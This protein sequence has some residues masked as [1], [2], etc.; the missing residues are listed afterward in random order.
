V[1]GRR[2][3]RADAHR[4]AAALEAQLSGM[5]EGGSGGE[6]ASPFGINELA[7]SR[8]P[9][10]PVTSRVLAELSGAGLDG[11]LQRIAAWARTAS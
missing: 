7:S 9:A 3:L 4:S 1:G 6:S 2:G 10:D 11:D 5:A 8:E